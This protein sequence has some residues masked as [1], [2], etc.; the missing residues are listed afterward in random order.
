MFDHRGLVLTSAKLPGPAL[1]NRLAADEY[2]FITGTREASAIRG[3]SQT[4][5]VLLAPDSKYGAKAPNFKKLA[6]NIPA[7]TDIC[8]VSD[9]EFSVH[10][11][12]H[13]KK[14]TSSRILCLTYDSFVV[15]IPL[16]AGVPKHE[17]VD[18]AEA[19]RILEC[20]YYTKELL[21]NILESDPMSVWLDIRRGD[22]VRIYRTSET[23]GEAIAYR[24]CV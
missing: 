18:P 9:K 1:Q 7:S 20:F 13:V 8:F 5:V 23:S 14:L 15:E 16:H 12:K 11:R 2:V 6:N 21:P 22:V 24:Q 19:R 17:I 10:V 4:T 3:R